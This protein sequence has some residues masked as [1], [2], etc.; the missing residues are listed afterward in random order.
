MQHDIAII[1][2]FIMVLLFIKTVSQKTKISSP[3]LLLLGGIAISLIT[4]R[5]LFELQ[6]ELIFLL[7]LPPLLFEASYGMSWHDL[8]FLRAPILWLSVGLVLF[9]MF[10]VALCCH[11][12]IPHFS[13][14]MGFLLG[15]IVAPPDAVAATSATKGLQLPRNVVTILEGESLIN[16]ASALIAYQYALLSL[17]S[18][19]IS[20]SVIV[21]SFVLK[22]SGGILL[23][24]A[25]AYFI[26]K[27]IKQTNDATTT[28]IL[29]VMTPLG[30]FLLAEELDI[31]GVLA[32][33]SCGVYL[34]WKTP[35]IT[36]FQDRHR[37]RE[38]WDVVGFL[39]NG[40][41][42]LFIGIQLP[43]LILHFNWVQLLTMIGD[44]LLISLTLIAARA[45]WIFTTASL[46]FL[47]VNR[48][49]DYR[50]YLT[51]EFYSNLLIVT[52]AGMRGVVSL[53]VALSVPV[54]LING[55]L[56]AA[57]EEIIFLTFIVISFTIVVNG[58]SLPKL[59]RW[60][61]LAN[62]KDHAERSNLALHQELFTKT[63]AFLNTTLRSK[64]PQAQLDA[65]IHEHKTL[66]H[67]VSQL[68][69]GSENFAIKLQL[70]HEV[71]QYKY[72]LIREFYHSN[73][74]SHESL[75]M[76]QHN[77]DNASLSL[78]SKMQL[79]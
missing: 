54:T 33:V 53:A 11:F 76:V 2:F 25:L 9:S 34:A 59:I 65:F 63:N 7:F 72:Q 22:S 49:Q 44:G 32:V 45:L 8:K 12:L 56:F 36:T 14:G 51:R 68:Q 47:I 73:L 6:P 69:E 58:L 24:L 3:I 17:T 71:I 57:R 10:S 20:L 13:W 38:L 55:T 4:Q 39:L 23:G 27:V 37:M 66:H 75:T 30:V 26:A 62:D 29:S 48:F 41:V 67:Q 61:N 1:S 52:W 78:S 77:L 70:E 18:S 42:F 50:A 64:F 19:H 40:L 31:S 28:A 21:S 43:K 46:K 35:F 60:L 5:T 74:Y 15:A 16:D 79:L